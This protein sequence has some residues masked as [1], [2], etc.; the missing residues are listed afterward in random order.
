MS[1]QLFRRG[2]PSSIHARARNP[3]AL[4]SDSNTTASTHIIATSGTAARRHSQR[5]NTAAAP[6]R[7]NLRFGLANRRSDTEKSPQYLSLA[8]GLQEVTVLGPRAGSVDHLFPAIYCNFRKA[9]ELFPPIYA[10]RTS[11][12]EAPITRRFHW[13]RCMPRAKSARAVTP[14]PPATQPGGQAVAHEI[15][16]ARPQEISKARLL[17]LREA[18]PKRLKTKSPADWQ[19]IWQ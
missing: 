8:R 10:T 18:H 5:K 13:L 19:L 6:P 16:L 17:R 14:I 4:T 7:S 12:L 1:R 2:H 15:P 9:S 11:P 3:F